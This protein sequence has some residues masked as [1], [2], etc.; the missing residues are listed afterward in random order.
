MNPLT[1]IL[2][3]SEKNGG[4]PLYDH[5]RHV[6]LVAV[7]IAEASGIDPTI[8]KLG[9][10]LHDIGKTHPDF[11]LRLRQRVDDFDI[12]FRHEI[13]SLFFLPLLP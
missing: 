11:Q 4:T 2:A 7:K 13:A 3:K 8:V 9:G 6:A 5:L 1:D 10:F 12:P